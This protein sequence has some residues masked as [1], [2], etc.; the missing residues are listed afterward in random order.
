N[1]SISFT[2]SLHDALPISQKDS[3]WLHHWSGHSVWKA[4][5]AFCP[6]SSAAESIR[7]RAPEENSRIAD[8]YPVRSAVS[9][10]PESATQAPQGRDRKSTRLNS[11]HDSISY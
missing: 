9:S 11:S 4:G 7:K 3:R 5:T 6:D 8:P 10:S 2:L 1:F